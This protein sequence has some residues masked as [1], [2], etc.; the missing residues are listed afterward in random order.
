[1]NYF[2]KLSLPQ[3]RTRS[4]KTI[5]ISTNPSQPIKLQSEKRITPVHGQLKTITLSQKSKL[6]SLPQRRTLAR[7][8]FQRKSY[9]EEVQFVMEVMGI[10]KWTTQQAL[11]PMWCQ[12]TWLTRA[13]LLRMLHSRRL[14]LFDDDVVKLI[15]DMSL[16]LQTK[17]TYLKHLIALMVQSGKLATHSRLLLKSLIRRGSQIPFQQAQPLT[18]AQLNKL[19]PFM[20]SEMAA[21]VLIAYKTA[22]RAGEVALLKRR[23]FIVARPDCIILY[24]GNKTKTTKAH[25]F[26]PDTMVVIE[27]AYTNQI[28]QYLRCLSPNTHI[29]TLSSMEITRFFR[30]HLGRGYS[31]HSIKR[32][33]IHQLM[34][35]VAGKRITLEEVMRIANHRQLPSLL[36]YSGV[37]EHTARALGTQNTTRLL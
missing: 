14:K 20:T 11:V 9:S 6:V 5:K 2:R 16:S 18:K 3:R 21:T 37:N 4:V 8:A 23:D 32:G 7:A 33:A 19:L 12:T 22:S 10:R 30:R 25:P 13:R 27:G 15:N 34:E 35:H 29:S 31:S 24:W 17:E 28:Y 36:R 1:M 26:R